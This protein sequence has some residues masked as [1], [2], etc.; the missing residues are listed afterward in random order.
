MALGKKMLSS[1]LPDECFKCKQHEDNGGKSHRDFWNEREKTLW[2][3]EEGIPLLKGLDLDMGNLCNLKCVTCNTHNST[4]WAEDELKLNG[5]LNFSGL[6]TINVNHLE[7]TNFENLNWLKFA[8]GEV[9]LIP[10][11]T[12][13]LEFF[14]ESNIASNIGLIYVVNNT[15]SPKKFLELW[16]HFRD[17][18]IILSIDGIDK[19]HDYIRYPSEW[20]KNQEIIL[21]Y[22]ELDLNIEVN[23]VV[24]L[25]NILHLERLSE[26]WKKNGKK[27]PI[28]YRILNYPEIMSINSLPDFN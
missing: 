4:S 24:S 22:L 13:V 2:K 12:K 9:L 14:I 19:Y 27:N 21:E 20:D 1:S 16:K 10:E 5:N 26:W 28:F 18:R 6:K 11:H 17:V 23:S 8:G 3:E 15:V 7:K 25:Y